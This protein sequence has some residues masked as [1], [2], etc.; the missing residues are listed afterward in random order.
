[1]KGIK[2]LL[3]ICFLLPIL[4]VAANIENVAFTKSSDKGV[5][6]LTF[7]H[8]VDVDFVAKAHS[9]LIKVPKAK[10]ADKWQT[11]MDVTSFGSVVQMIN[12]KRQAGGVSLT[13]KNKA[14]YL[15]THHWDKT[16]LLITL[17][18]DKTQLAA[19]YVGKPISLNFQSISLRAVLQI[20]A[21]FTG[22]NIVASDAVQGNITL[23]LEQVPW[24]QALD[25]ILQSKGL[26][27]RK[28]GN[29][30]YV[31][32]Q[33]EIA[34]QEKTALEAKAQQLELEPLVVSYLRINYAKAGSIAKLLQ[35]KK[36]SILSKRGRI[37]FDERTNTLL[38]K[39]TPENL[40][41]I[42]TLLAKLD[43]PVE[44]VLIEA[45]IVEM[46]KNALSEFGVAQRADSS[47]NAINTVSAGNMAGTHSASTLGVAGALNNPISGTPSGV[48]SLA[49]HELPVG[50]MLDLEL[51]A[52]ESEGEAKVISSPRLVVSNKQEAYIE[53]GSQV[54]YLSA[55]A[56]GANQVQFKKAVLS[57]RVTP[58]ITPN[59]KV[60]LDLKVN[61]DKISN[62]SIKAG[63]TPV[64]DTR[65]VKTQVIVN[66]GQTLVLGGIYE[67]TKENTVQ[68]VPFLGSL[69]V[70]GWLFKNHYQ[71]GVASEMLIFITPRIIHASDKAEIGLKPKMPD[72]KEV[73]ASERMESG[74]K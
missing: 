51:Q 23:N 20:I 11:S 40:D 52:L 24:D 72:F 34:N 37:S 12:V 8:R 50:F 3:I 74:E 1:M 66:D 16:K 25:I 39:D 29:V 17:L 56:S 60:M 41:Q 31:A 22:I 36:N 62:L 71:N 47:G 30:I 70:I 43:I 6:T 42:K 46:D 73:L 5:F 19:A 61:K 59:H 68:R 10:I 4:S 53:Q 28:S 27:M 58:Q 65:E 18:P 54:P 63:D 32:P 2:R 38:I 44:Q 67:K 7:D 69:P 49:F 14:A 21:E 13:L 26:A 55:T 48:L 64:I 9:L 57:L 15:F 33:T 35:D 45:Q